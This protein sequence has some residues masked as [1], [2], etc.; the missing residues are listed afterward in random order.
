MP[1]DKQLF[2]EPTDAEKLAIID[3]EVASIGRRIYQLTLAA[4]FQKQVGDSDRVK[5]HEDEALKLVQL[6]DLYTAERKKIEEKV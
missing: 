6:Q 4:R 5:I 1:D 3:G 2:V